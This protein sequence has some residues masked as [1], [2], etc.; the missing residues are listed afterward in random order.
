MDPNWTLRAAAQQKFAEAPIPAQ[1]QSGYRQ[2]AINLER[3][4]QMT[5]LV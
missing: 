3:A 5:L 2:L 4:G 1:Y